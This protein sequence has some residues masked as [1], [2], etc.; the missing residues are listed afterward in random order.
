MESAVSVTVLGRS[1]LELSRIFNGARETHVFREVQERV[2]ILLDNVL[3]LLV[4][5]H[6][7]E[8]TISAD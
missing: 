4:I 3:L 6:L 7:S 8:M 2:V 5:V 1:A